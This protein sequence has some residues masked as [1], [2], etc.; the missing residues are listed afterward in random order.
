MF[1]FVGNLC[2]TDQ[3]LVM[4]NIHKNHSTLHCCIY[5]EILGYSYFFAYQFQCILF[6]VT[7]THF[8]TKCS[9]YI[10]LRMELHWGAVSWQFFYKIKSRSIHVVMVDLNEFSSIFQKVQHF[11]SRHQKTT[12][13]LLT[14]HLKGKL[15]FGNAS[16]LYRRS[17]VYIKA[18]VTFSGASWKKVYFSLFSKCWWFETKQFTGL[19]EFIKLYE[20]NPS[21]KPFIFTIYQN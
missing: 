13:N 20:Q 8:T 16:S 3:A 9:K 14:T 18:M 17:Y 2:L 1:I 21:E 5:F 10:P 12:S 7:I 11:H 19:V 4:K 15:M 6:C